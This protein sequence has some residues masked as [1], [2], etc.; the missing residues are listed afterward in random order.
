MV[1]YAAGLAS[2][3]YAALRALPAKTRF[4]PLYR[5][6]NTAGGRQAGAQRR[7]RCKGNALF[8]L[9]GDDLPAAGD[10]HLPAAGFTVV[11]A[12]YQSAWTE[13]ADVVLPARVWTEK[14]GHVV[15]LEGREL[16]VIALVPPR[17]RCAP[18]TPP[19]WRSPGR[20][21]GTL[22]EEMSEWPKK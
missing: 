2:A 11:Q 20:A 3:V 17:R 5:G 21:D 13:A 16:P 1:L 22:R 14:E 8:V 9:A 4:L 6:T 12:A 15:N 19:R 10:G 7:G 18:P